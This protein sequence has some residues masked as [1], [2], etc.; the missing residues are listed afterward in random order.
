MFVNF[1]ADDVFICTS[2]M[3][4]RDLTTPAEAD[5]I[6]LFKFYTSNAASGRILLDNSKVYHSAT[7]T[8][9]EIPALPEPEPPVD[10]DPPVVNPDIPEP[11]PEEPEEPK[12]PETGEVRPSLNPDVGFDDVTGTEPT[13]PDDGETNDGSGWT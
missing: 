6:N 1:Y 5:D 2:T 9:F 13:E 3:M 4:F 8:E 11:E 7:Y 10:P 12:G